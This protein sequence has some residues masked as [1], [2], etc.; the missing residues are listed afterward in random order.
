MQV[1]VRSHGRPLALQ[2]GGDRCRQEQK[3][4]SRISNTKA[5]SDEHLIHLSSLSLS[6]ASLQKICLLLSIHISVYQLYDTKGQVVTNG[7]IRG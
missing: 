2:C 4:L 1:E 3:D 6:F 7:F 5:C